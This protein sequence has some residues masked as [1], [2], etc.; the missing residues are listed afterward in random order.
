LIG[1]VVNSWGGVSEW[2]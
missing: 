2:E 1:G